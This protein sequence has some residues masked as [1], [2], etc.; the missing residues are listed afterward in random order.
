MQS[1]GKIGV[2][3]IQRLSWW[4][5]SST[6]FVSMRGCFFSH[7][8]W[9]CLV[10]LFQFLNFFSAVFFGCETDRCREE[11]YLI[12][13]SSVVKMHGNSL[14][15]IL[16]VVD[17]PACQTPVGESDATRIRLVFAEF[18]ADYFV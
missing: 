18:E 9:L 13:H 10:I 4:R 8:K 6:G 7:A 2:Q 3:I 14:R 15:A 12:Y 11:I 5:N 1:D 17:L 16:N